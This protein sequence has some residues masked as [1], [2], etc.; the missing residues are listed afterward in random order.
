LEIGLTRRGV[1]GSRVASVIGSGVSA[2]VVL[3]ALANFGFVSGEKEADA[4]IAWAV[5]TAITVAV[6][7]GLFWYLSRSYETANAARLAT[8]ALV[9]A[10]LTVLGIFTFWLGIQPVFAAAA[11]LTGTGALE[12]DRA[13]T[14]NRVYVA[15]MVTTAAFAFG[16]FLAIFG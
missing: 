8:S 9:F 1:A 11:L 6:G 5:C 7:G 16:S 15:W 10:V 12:R 3:T 13:A 4:F 2:G 14:R